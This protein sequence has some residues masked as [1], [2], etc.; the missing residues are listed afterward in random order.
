MISAPFKNTPVKPIF[1]FS[2]FTDPL[3]VASQYTTTDHGPGVSTLLMGMLQS[4]IPPELCFLPDRLCDPLNS[5]R[6]PAA[7]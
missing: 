6:S 3:G 7:S 2:K 1:Q 5:C 4:I